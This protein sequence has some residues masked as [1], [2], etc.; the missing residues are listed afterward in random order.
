VKTGLF[1]YGKPATTFIVGPPG[2][3]LQNTSLDLYPYDPARARQLL[4]QSGVPI[5]V[6]LSLTVTA[7]SAQDAIAAVVQQNLQQIGINLNIV[8]KDFVSNEN[9]IDSGNFTMGTTFWG[10]FVGDPSEQPL[11]WM[12]PSF[13]CDSYFTGFNDPASIA[14]VHKAVNE[15]DP[16][17]AQALFDDVQ[18]M[19]AT[20]AHAI[21]LYFP[22]LTY[23]ASPKLVGFEANPFG[24]YPFEKFALQP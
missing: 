6:S 17:K 20:T 2:E 21:P 19:V 13:C 8:R 22:D 23:V 5:P 11:F 16:A 15:T 3:T 9:D 7:G 18:R 10:D 14:L 4:Q 12:D 24:T 1:G